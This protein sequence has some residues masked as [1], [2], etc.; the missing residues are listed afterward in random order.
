[1]D[2]LNRATSCRLIDSNHHHHQHSMATTKHLHSNNTVGS[3]S[4]P[5][6][7]PIPTAATTTTLATTAAAST[8]ASSSPQLSPSSCSVLIV[9]KRFLKGVYH[10]TG[11]DS[12]PTLRAGPAR[13]DVVF[14]QELLEIY[15]QGNV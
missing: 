14:V 3:N 2:V 6:P 13:D 9:D 15:G 8:V 12:I 4:V 1:M 11:E 7:I 10:T 5:I